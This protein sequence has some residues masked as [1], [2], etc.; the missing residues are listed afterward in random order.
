ME[1]LVTFH[2]TKT[3][4]DYG[5]NV[6]VDGQYVG[7]LMKSI[8]DDWHFRYPGNNETKEVITAKTEEEAKEKVIKHLINK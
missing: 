7:C 1:S 2:D 5:I 4:G 8:N 3:I 6:N